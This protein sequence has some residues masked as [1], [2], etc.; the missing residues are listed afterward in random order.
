MGHRAGSRIDRRPALPLCRRYLLV[1]FGA[2]HVRLAHHGKS[3]RC[4][5]RVACGVTAGGQREVLGMW[6]D[7]AAGAHG[8]PQIFSELIQRGVES[9]GYVAAQEPVDAAALSAS[10]PSAVA[11]QSRETL[12]S[13]GESARG[14]T[15]DL[16][17]LLRSGLAAVH[18]AEDALRSALRRHQTFEDEQTAMAFVSHVMDRVDRSLLARAGVATT[19]G[20]SSRR[21]SDG[22]PRLQRSRTPVR[23]RP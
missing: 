4:V 16:P 9:I 7:S 1:H 18:L 3:W 15:T 21:R 19:S 11:V 5:G 13:D 2:E 10:F 8:W 14:R 12:R 23:F 22:L 17:R 6:A 20:G